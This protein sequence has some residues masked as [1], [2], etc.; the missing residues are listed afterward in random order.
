MIPSPMFL[1]WSVEYPGER[2]SGFRIAYGEREK[3]KEPS[4]YLC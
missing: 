3:S 1:I 4:D 2:Y